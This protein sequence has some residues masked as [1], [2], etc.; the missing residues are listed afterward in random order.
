M[1]LIDP[2]QSAKDG[3]LFVIHCNM[4]K[5]ILKFPDPGSLVEFILTYR[6]TDAETNASDFSLVAQLKAT[7]IKTAVV[8]Y[9]ATYKPFVPIP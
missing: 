9:G 4:K 5:V 6:V 8:R 3:P 2:D 1:F 7:L